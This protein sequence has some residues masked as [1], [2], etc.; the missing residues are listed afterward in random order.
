MLLHKCR[1]SA[2]ATQGRRF[3]LFGRRFQSY[4]IRESE[5]CEKGDRLRAANLSAYRLLCAQVL[6][7]PPAKGTRARKLPI[8]RGYEFISYSRGKS[9]HWRCLIAGAPF[10]HTGRMLLHKCRNSATATQGRRFFLFGRRFQ[11]YY[12]RESEIYEKGDRPRAANFSAYPT[13]LLA[14]DRLR[15]ANFS[16]HRYSWHRLL[17]GCA[18]AS[19]RVLEATSS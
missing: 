17:K 7:A 12:I 19:Y 8:V 13:V 18:P 10:S 16:A 5:I 2:T 11:S 4:Y 15:A 6:L 3:F 9:L 1:N 14:A